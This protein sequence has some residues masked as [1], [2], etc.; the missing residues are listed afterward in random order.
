MKKFIFP[1]VLVFIFSMVLLS[2]ESS[3]QSTNSDSYNKVYKAVDSIRLALQSKLGKTVPSLNIYIKTPAEDIFVS[4]FSNQTNAVTKDTYFRFASNTKNFTSAAVLNMQEEGWLNIESKIIDLI[5]GSN[6]P[7]VPDTP[8]WN[9]PY[10][11]QITI[12]NL[13]QHSAGVY[14]VSNDTVPGYNYGYV[15][16]VLSVDPEHQ[17]SVSELVGVVT[18]FNLS[19]YAPGTNYHYSNTGYNILTEIIS[20][21]YSYR[22]GSAKK[23]SDYLYDY[24]VGGSSPVPLNIKFPYLA[25]DKQMP[26]P[27]IPSLIYEQNGLTT[28]TSEHNMSANIG[29]GNGYGTMNMLTTYISSMITGVNVL[30][31][32]SVNRMK[33]DISP[34]STTY[35]LGCSH[36]ANLGYGHTGATHGY[37]SCMF[38]DPETG[39][40]VVGMTPVWDLTGGEENYYAPYIAMIDACYKSRSVLGYPGKP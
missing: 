25:G 16:G 22:S 27:N 29:E 26:A 8:E 36:V 1:F 34:G 3:V 21:V 17:F 19:Y 33:T 4:S 15:L 10:K 35:A 37:Y 28:N 14:D 18:N 20:R 12:K 31:P 2:C 7:Y 23:Y 38:Y 24:I 11:N 39:V 40:S 30:T 13:L 5:P 6:I 32:A 9:I